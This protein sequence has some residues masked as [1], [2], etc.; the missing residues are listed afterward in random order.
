MANGTFSESRNIRSSGSIHTHTS[1]G[2]SPASQTAS[3]SLGV[4]SDSGC[5]VPM[6]TINWGS[7]SPGGTS[8]Q[9][10]YVENT[11]TVSLTLSMK[12]SNWNPTSA[13]G[14]ITISWNQ[15]GTMLAP[16]QSTAAII[17]LTASAGTTG[18]T[19]FSVQISISGTE[20][21][22]KMLE[23]L[24]KG[25]SHWMCIYI[26]IQAL[27]LARFIKTHYTMLFAYAHEKACRST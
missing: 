25:L 26:H 7:A 5:T 24:N 16:G 13:N 17:T 21:I 18:I 23:T 19:S 27:E 15:Q 9:T 6:T 8:T 4:Y 1:S 3:S 2:I 22:A 14:P 20:G 12:T 11:G 10:I